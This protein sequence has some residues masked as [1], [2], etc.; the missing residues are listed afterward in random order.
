MLSSSLCLTAH[1]LTYSYFDKS[2]EKDAGLLL[3]FYVFIYVSTCMCPSPT[4]HPLS[5]AI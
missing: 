5:A 3:S 1:G 4:L 2:I